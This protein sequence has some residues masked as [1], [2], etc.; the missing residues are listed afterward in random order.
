MKNV[1]TTTDQDSKLTISQEFI[2]STLQKL[3]AMSLEGKPFSCDKFSLSEKESKQLA[4]ALSLLC[5]IFGASISQLE[6]LDRGENDSFDLS[7]R[8][9]RQHTL[10]LMGILTSFMHYRGND[11]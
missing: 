5:D 3:K 11:L 2:D 4:K 6:R 7:C 9:Q 10:E 8:V 1:L